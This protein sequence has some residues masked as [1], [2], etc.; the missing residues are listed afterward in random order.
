MGH[1]IGFFNTVLCYYLSGVDPR[2][3]RDEEWAHTIKYLEQI[4]RMEERANE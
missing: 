3:M 4:R 2:E 1:C